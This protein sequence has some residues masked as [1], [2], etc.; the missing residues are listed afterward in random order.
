MVQPILS[1]LLLLFFAAAFSGFILVIFLWADDAKRLNKPNRRKLLRGAGFTFSIVLSLV[2]INMAHSNL[3][4][5]K[6]I[7]LDEFNDYL[8]P[9]PDSARYVDGSYS[10]L[11]MH[12]DINDVITIQVDSNTYNQILYALN[13][14]KRFKHYAPVPNDYLWEIQGEEQ[15][16]H[17]LT[18]H[19]FLKKGHPDTEVYMMNDNQSI[20][21][22][23]Y[24]E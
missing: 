16:L 11:E 5:E 20:R 7:L 14:N 12:G 2:F 3:R 9:L 21:L 6:D 17:I 13:N 1:T 4:A 8:F 18:K 22:H 23:L 24:H 10:G 19:F 15:K